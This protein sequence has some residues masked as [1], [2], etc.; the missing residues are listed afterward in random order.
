ML[1][2]I[3]KK[4]IESIPILSMSLRA[5]AKQSPI[6]RL[7][8]QDKLIPFNGTLRGF[9]LGFDTGGKGTRPTQPAASQRHNNTECW[10]LTQKNL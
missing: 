8:S 1:I 4:K 6:K 10:Q 2:S 3:G 7:T 5:K 9:G